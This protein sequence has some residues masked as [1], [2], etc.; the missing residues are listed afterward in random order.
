VDFLPWQLTAAY[1]LDLIF[2]D[3]TWAPHPIRWIGVL[4]GAVEERLYPKTSHA[5]L[6]L[7]AGSVFWAAVM[8]TVVGTAWLLLRMAGLIHPALAS[9]VAVWLAC[10]TLATRSLH[11]ESS[12]VATALCRA[13]LPGARQA[14]S[15][16]VSRETAE[17]TEEDILRA[18]L[19]T[20]AENLSDGVVAPLFYLA[21]G[22]SVLAMAYKAVS[23]MDSMVGYRNQRYRSFGTFAA[24]ADDV[25]NWIP[26]RLTGWLLVAAA[27]CWQLNWQNARR[28]MVRDGHQHKSP[29]AGIPEAAAAGA[30]DVRLGGPGT[31]FGEVVIKPT[32][33]DPSQPLNLQSY[34]RLIRMLY[35]VSLMAM[36]LACGGRWLV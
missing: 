24:R 4:I 31:Y 30:L 11:G 3:P 26:A 15:R 2:G 5:A 19:E 12:K 18:L 28:I 23:T 13:D 16:L 10:T 21:V 14:L 35:T 8:G 6:H 22:G 20:V 32:L 9:L 33:G 29:N 36:L 7:A 34:N 27:Y 25:A 17:M 1:L